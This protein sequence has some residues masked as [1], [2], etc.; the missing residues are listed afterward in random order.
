MERVVKVIANFLDI[1]ESDIKADT[2]LRELTDDSLDLVELI[3]TLEDEFQIDIQD[4]D[5]NK[6]I[7]IKDIADYMERGSVKK[8]GT[9]ERAFGTN[10]SGKMVAM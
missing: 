2:E 5:I 6:M 10:S 4:E 3:I 1:E 8:T 7:T 9:T